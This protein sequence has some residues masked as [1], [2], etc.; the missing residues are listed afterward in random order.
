MANKHDQAAKAI[1][2]QFGFARSTSEKLGKGC[3]LIWH[4]LALMDSQE[5]QLLLKH[6]LQAVVE[7]GVRQEA[8]RP[9]NNKL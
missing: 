3:E 5:Q 8:G 2:E 4:A 1:K 6:G 7:A 9:C